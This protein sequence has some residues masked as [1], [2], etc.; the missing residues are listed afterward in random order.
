MKSSTLNFLLFLRPIYHALFSPLRKLKNAKCLNRERGFYYSG[1]A[2]FGRA[3]LYIVGAQHDRALLRSLM[4][5]CSSLLW[6]QKESSSHS[7]SNTTL[8]ERRHEEENL[9]L[10]MTILL[11]KVS[12]NYFFVVV[13]G[14]EMA[15]RTIIEEALLF[16]K[17]E[18]AGE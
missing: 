10:L 1:V 11:A 6:R 5:A 4:H 3:K 14:V 12:H 18:I 9:A 17:G 15:D 7:S 13:V 8:N 2:G 16:W